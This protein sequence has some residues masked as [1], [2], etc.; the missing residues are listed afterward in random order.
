MRP[1]SSFSSKA[2]TRGGALRFNAGGLARLS[3][4][5]YGRFADY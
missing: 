5:L 4:Q 1:L 3:G 2:S